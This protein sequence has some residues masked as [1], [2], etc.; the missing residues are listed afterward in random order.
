ML[1]FGPVK[2]V[3]Q[4]FQDLNP[5]PLLA[6]FQPRRFYWCQLVYWQ[7]VVGSRAGV[8]ELLIDSYSVNRWRIKVFTGLDKSQLRY[9][10]SRYFDMRMHA[11]VPSA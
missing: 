1:L 7:L 4:H 6:S 10:K 8:A 9:I 3:R 2:A 11:V 5:E